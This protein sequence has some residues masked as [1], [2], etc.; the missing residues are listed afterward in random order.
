MLCSLSPAWDLDV[1]QLVLEWG[2]GEEALVGRSWD[3]LR[4]SWMA[5]AALVI[6]SILFWKDLEGRS[7]VLC[8]ASGCVLK[9]GGK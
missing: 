9:G 4:L 5:L 8:P 2:G 6:C 7:V 1:G 3:E